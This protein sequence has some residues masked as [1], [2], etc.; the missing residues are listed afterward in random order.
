MGKEPFERKRPDRFCIDGYLKS[1]RG[2]WKLYLRKADE[3]V[4]AFY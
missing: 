1:R 4:R 2:M 3:D